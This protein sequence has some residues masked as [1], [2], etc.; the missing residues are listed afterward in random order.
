M[1]DQ[2]AE[3]P[4]F[5][6]PEQWRKLEAIVERAGGTGARDQF[7]DRL[8]RSLFESMARGWKN[9][10]D[11]WNGHNFGRDEAAL[12][13]HV[14]ETARA[15]KDAL[16]ALHF[17][18]HLIWKADA[19]VRENERYAHFLATIE[20]VESRAGARASPRR[21]HAR[22][23]RDRFIRDVGEAWRELGLRI[24][25]SPTS[26]FVKFVEIAS[27]GVCDFPYDAARGTISNV[28][29]KWPRRALV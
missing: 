6:S 15:L 10:M 22:F 13:R 9:R 3:P 1:T 20:Q 11:K 5:Y 23:A 12:H 4:P 29:R 7:N 27:E 17:P 8:R 21:K 24:S 14:E 18:A 28:V 2:S 26:R 19:D 16:K 25:N